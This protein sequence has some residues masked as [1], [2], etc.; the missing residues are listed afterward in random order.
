MLKEALLLTI[1]EVYGMQIPNDLKWAVT[2]AFK[3][4]RN[5][6]IGQDPDLLVDPDERGK[7]TLERKRIVEQSWRKV[8]Q[9]PPHVAGRILYKHFFIIDPSFI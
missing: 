3:T 2:K 7:L 5:F 1:E 4:I 8:S 9:H 6:I